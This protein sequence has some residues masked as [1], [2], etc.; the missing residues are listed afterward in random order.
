MK[1][2]AILLIAISAFLVS[3]SCSKEE[4]P[5]YTP[6]I[7]K[8]PAGE[9]IGSAQLWV[10]NGGKTKL[11]SQQGSLDIIDNTETIYPA[12]T[13]DPATHY[14]E[15][16]GFGAALTGSSA[17]LIS[18]LETLQ[19]NILLRELFDPEDGIGMS[20]LRHSIGASDF[21]LKDFTYNDVLP[22]E[23]DPELTQ[24]SIAEDEKHIIPVFQDILQIAP[25]IKI[26]GSPWSA[27]AWMK[28][29]QSLQGGALK[30]K[31]YNAYAAYFVK[32]IK[33]YASHGIAIDAITPQ[34]EPLH[35]AGYPTMS[36]GASAQAEF[37]KNSLGPLFEEEG[38]DTKIIA[39]DHNFDETGYPISVLGDP[40]ANKYI[41]GSAFHAYAGDV[42]A[43]SVVH[44]AF[45]DKGLY[46]T[47]ISGG[48]WATNFSDNLKWYINN[49]LIGTTKNWSKNALF[50]NLALN[51]NFGPTNNGCQ[52]CR[53]VITIRSSG[54]IEKNVEYYSIGHFSK[55]VRPG[56]H[57]IAATEFPS[58]SGLKSVSFINADTSK[59]LIVLN[60]S[61]ESKLFS[62]IINNSLFNAQLEANAVAS[63]IWN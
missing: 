12:I 13:I 2:S 58:G 45:P 51:E 48:Q 42:S 53:G 24:F 32:Y 4:E 22:G 41:S 37:I 18:G 50:W 7:I 49:I 26:M 35:Q 39:Y 62:V 10:T 9:I 33:A 20:Y 28:T 5:A 8:E 29:N 21:S 31:W 11:L 14:Q 47:E 16:E 57:R 36:M 30:P 59:V 6:P 1:R 61:S 63:I 46:F 23:E 56:A 60:E 3:L 19:K 17:Y 52:D 54:E 43:M 55:F 25:G 27:P 40:Q 44:Q 15:I 38:I 34:N